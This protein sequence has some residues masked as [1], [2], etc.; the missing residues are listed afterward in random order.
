MRRPGLLVIMLTLAAAACQPSAVTSTASSTPT[1]QAPSPEPS[2][3]PSPS[4]TASIPSP[5]PAPA[6]RTFTEAFEGDLNH[7]AFLQVDNGPSAPQ[8]RI[9]AGYLRFDM[10]AANQWLYAI[11]DPHSY[12]DVRVDAMVS[13]G[14][15]GGAGGVI[16]RY[17]Q[18]GGWYELDV[19]ADQTYVLLY[20][21]WLSPG[22]ARYTPIVRAQSEKIQP[23]DNEIGL[24]CQGN[25]LT[26]FING[27]QMRQRVE[28]TFALTSGNIGVAAASFETAP[29]SILV[30]WVKVAE[31]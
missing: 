26:P 17:T 1:L 16:C 20:G 6:L 5:T 14:S 18:A 11:Y 21:Q 15:T 3:T 31:P 23:G 30:D 27:V 2:D 8:P 24:Q 9:S 13:D 22:L 7:W 19:H 28:N 4:A 10:T 29:M 12:A 25:V